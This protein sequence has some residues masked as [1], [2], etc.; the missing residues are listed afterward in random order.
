M[1]SN[2]PSCVPIVSAKTDSLY[3]VTSQK[4]Y[5]ILRES[6]RNLHTERPPAALL[7]M[8]RVHRH[9]RYGD[10]GIHVHQTR[11]VQG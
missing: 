10:G 4:S 8:L 7:L 6:A 1:I 11:G 3:A 9:S 5:S 2:D